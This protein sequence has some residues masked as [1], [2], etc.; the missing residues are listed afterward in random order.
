[1]GGGH[2]ASTSALLRGAFHAGASASEEPR[3]LEDAAAEVD[4]ED[5]FFKG[6]V[7]QSVTS[8]PIR[9]LT[10]GSCQGCTSNEVQITAKLF[11]CVAQH[12]GGCPLQDSCTNGD[13]NKESPC[14]TE[15]F[16]E[17]STH[18]W[19]CPPPALATAVPAPTPAPTPAQELP[20]GK[21]K[22]KQ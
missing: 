4:T 8:E 1:M 12:G 11:E 16:A 14:C 3:R 10:L 7:K 9:R 20:K 13:A 19:N 17:P 21:S 22:G 2:V 6:P 18:D 15:Y 5:D